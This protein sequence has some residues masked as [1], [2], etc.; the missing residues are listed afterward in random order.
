MPRF[1]HSY[2]KDINNDTT[3]NN[4][5]NNNCTFTEKSDVVFLPPTIVPDKHVLFTGNTRTIDSARLIE[6]IVR[7]GKEKKVLGV[8]YH[9]SVK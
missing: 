5:Y 7:S 2:L 4:S 3:T 9:S 8:E 1:F 6:F